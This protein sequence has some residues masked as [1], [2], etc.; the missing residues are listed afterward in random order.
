M[1]IKLP[2]LNFQII[3]A[4]N[5]AGVKKHMSLIIGQKLTG[6]TAVAGSLTQDIPNDGSEDTLFGARS[7]LAGMV[8][9]FK[10]ENSVSQ[11]DA[12][13]LD[14]ATGTQATAVLV[15]AGT[16]TEDGTLFVSVGS[17]K[18]FRVK[19]DVL[20]GDLHTEI[21]T[22]IETAFA[23]FTKSP[24]VGADA[25]G[26]ITF[27]A[28]ND[29]TLA[30]DWGI[31][32]EG[33]VAGISATLTGWT[34]GATDPSL[35][36]MLDVIANNRYQTVIWPSSYVLTV[37]EDELNS[38]FNTE[39][40]IMDGVAFQVKADTLSNLKTYVSAL[41]SQS[42]VIPGIKTMDLADRKGSATL[43]MLDIASAE[44]CAIRALRLTPG[45][46]LTQYLTTV[47]SKDQV[48]GSHLATLPYFNTSL[49]NLPIAN[50]VDEFS[51]EDRKELS[52]NALSAYGPNEAFN[53]TIFGEF[54]TTYLT[55]TAGNPDSSFKYL[56]TVDTESLIREFFFVNFKTRYAQ[57]RLTNG[58]LKAGFDMAN[59]ASIR[60]FARRLYGELANNVITQSGQVASDDFNTNLAISLNLT[61]GTVTF[62]MAPLLV[63]QFRASIGT[64]QINFGGN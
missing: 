4:S 24:F 9:A 59:E 14:D 47:A 52:E 1:A 51:D 42:L 16:A 62:S 46:Q 37:I 3:P 22:A 44:I 15:M 21:A 38:R 7:H 35:T 20:T 18:D 13:A 36:G 55:D 12:I 43:E 49:P 23:L 39:N 11:L 30:N 5:L 6:G 8:R 57:T 63:S 54:V 45:A 34:G 17:K 48:G 26:T 27:T 10:R 33:T 64:F 41:N 31:E 40:A 28:Q 32:V 56:N 2:R 58:D 60:V 19:I 61:T 29:G 50:P 25:I 53:G